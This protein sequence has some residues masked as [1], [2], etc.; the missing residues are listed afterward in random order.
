MIDLSGKKLL[1]MGGVKCAENIVRSARKMGV[2]T[3]VTDYLAD[4]PAKKIADE[5]HMVST[6]DVDAVV[7]L[8]KDL[9]VDGVFTSYIDSMMIYC[10]QVCERLGLP[11]YTTKEQI[12]ITNDKRRFKQ[13]CQMCG[14]PVVQEY[15]FNSNNTEAYK[16]FLYPVIVKPVDSSGSKGISVC[17]EAKDFMAAY[18]K[19][20]S[21]SQSGQVLVERYMTGDEVVIYYTIQDGYVSLSGMCDRYTSK[22]QNGL[23]QL[24]TAYIFPSK[25][26]REYQ[27]NEDEKVRAMLRSIGLQ[28][29]VIF[30]QGFIEN[31]SCYFYEAGYRFAGAQEYKVISAVNGINTMDMMVRHSLTGKMSGWDVRKDD[32]PNFKEVACKLS[33]LVKTGR[34]SKIEGLDEIEK[35]PGVTAIASVYEDGDMVEGAGTLNQIVVR[36]FMKADDMKG[37]ADVID[38]TYELLKVLDENGDDMLFG[39]FDTSILSEQY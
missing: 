26:L 7:K 20:M 36:I 21:F 32:N 1:I 38:R 16:K 8:A 6:T 5:S 14:V 39:N 13:Q 17:A 18:N 30:L 4:S 23:A 10:Q 11:F 15:V 37:L 3:I 24:P 33:P 29:G 22:E 27:N 19:A 31:N 34:I 12:G 28:N 9:K 2:Y 35:L 25:Y